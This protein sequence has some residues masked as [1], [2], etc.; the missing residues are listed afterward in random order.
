VVAQNDEEWIAEWTRSGTGVAG[1]PREC[2]VDVM[3]DGTIKRL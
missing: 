2:S 3:D 1:S